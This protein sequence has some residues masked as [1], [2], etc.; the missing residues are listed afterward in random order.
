MTTP[1]RFYDAK[2]MAKIAEFYAG[3]ETL[4]KELEGTDEPSAVGPLSVYS[5]DIVIRHRDGYTVGRIGFEDDYPFFELTD[6]HYGEEPETVET[7]HK[8]L[9][10][11]EYG[12]QAHIRQEDTGAGRTQQ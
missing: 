7:V 4:I 5:M 6:E 8:W 2:Q 11:K 9:S 12:I 3:V 1:A 10:D